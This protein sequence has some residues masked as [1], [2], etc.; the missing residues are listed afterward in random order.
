M[1][2]EPVPPSMMPREIMRGDGREDLGLDQPL[3][4]P[5]VVVCGLNE[6]ACAMPGGLFHAAGNMAMLQY[7]RPP[8]NCQ[9]KIPAAQAGRPFYFAPCAN[10]NAIKS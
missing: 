8:R 10:R 4:W 7:T 9:R 3:Q 2:T 6:P 1:V 5:G